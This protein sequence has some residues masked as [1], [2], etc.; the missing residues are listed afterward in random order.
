MKHQDAEALRTTILRLT[1]QAG[2]RLT[3]P[4]AEDLAA[5]LQL[6][7]ETNKAFNLTAIKKPIDAARLHVLDSLMPLPEVGDAPPGALADI[8]SGA[9]YPGIPLGIVTRRPVVLVESVGKKATFLA[10]VGQTL[11]S[12]RGLTVEKSRA[13]D[14]GRRCGGCF[15]VVTARALSKLPSVV[16]LAA[17]LLREH[18]VFIA[19]KGAVTAEELASGDRVAEVVGLRRVSKRDFTL[20]E[21]N[22]A[23][24]VIAYERIGEPLVPLPRETGYA[25]HRPLA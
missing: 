15:A 16:E 21:G 19:M 25:Q 3:A 5:H 24:C 7:L 17:P 22:E 10:G 18:G 14:L 4:Q 8:G 13:E 2:I 23:R 1:T 20:P 11:S 12:Y 9:G 6:V